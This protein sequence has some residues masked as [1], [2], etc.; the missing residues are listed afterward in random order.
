M[1]YFEIAIEIRSLQD[2][3][4]CFF[5]FLIFLLFSSNARL[6]LPQALCTGSDGSLYIGDYNLIR[7]LTPSGSLITLLELRFVSYFIFLLEVKHIEISFLFLLGDNLSL[8][9]I[10]EIYRNFSIVDEKLVLNL[11]SNLFLKLW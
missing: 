9:W 3:F 4:I 2:T 5:V 7:K 8:Q 11:F 10:S 6:F 1:A